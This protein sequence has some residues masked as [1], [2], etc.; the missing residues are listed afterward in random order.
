MIIWLI[1]MSGAGKTTIGER[2][3]FEL[4]RSDPSTVF[5]DG[6][7][8]REIFDPIPDYSIEGRRQNAQR[9]SKLC[10]FLDTQQ[11]DVVACVLSIFP[12]WQNWN[13][14]NFGDYF[15]IFLDVSFE[16]LIRRD[17]KGLYQKALSG[18][19]PNF[20]GV[21]IDFPRPPDPDMIITESQMEHGVE[22]NVQDIIRLLNLD[23]SEG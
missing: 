22:R 23:R 21:D 3:F 19:L 4:K 5:V 9:L 16:T 15:E 17:P 11:I 10:K 12:E 7:V 13:R 14:K 8:I 6:D 20:V 18:Q 2:L 1:G